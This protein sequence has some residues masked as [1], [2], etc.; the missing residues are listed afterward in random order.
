[1]IQN[2]EMTAELLPG[3]EE[4]NRP[5][6]TFC[7]V[8]W[9]KTVVRM[10]HEAACGKGTMCRDGIHQLYRIIADITADKGRPDDLELLRELCH[11]ISTAADCQLAEQAAQRILLSLERFQDEWTAHLSRKRCTAM[12]CPAFYT[13][14]ID[15]STCTG[16]GTCASCCPEKAVAGGEGLIHVVD[17]GLCSRCGSCMTACPAGAVVKAG[18]VKPRGPESPVPVGS[19]GGAAGGMRRRRRGG[20]A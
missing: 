15:P 5:A 16:C 19:F 8:D 9:A 6:G 1:M 20:E 3:A 12:T 10:A 14:H 7:P 18:A 17:L 13:V 11:T 2:C 4:L